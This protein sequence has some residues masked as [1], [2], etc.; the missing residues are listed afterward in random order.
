VLVTGVVE[1][2][3]LNCGQSESAQGEDVANAMAGWGQVSMAFGWVRQ[4]MDVG[5]EACV[6]SRQSH[7]FNET[8]VICVKECSSNISFGGNWISGLI[9]LLLGIMHVS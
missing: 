8:L 9:S 7:L 2:F 5:D 1:Q 4:C 3:L 6:D